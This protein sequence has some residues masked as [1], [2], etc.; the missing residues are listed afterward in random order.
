[1]IGVIFVIV[2]SFFALL[3][4]ELIAFALLYEYKTCFLSP[5][6]ILHLHLTKILHLLP[7]IV[8]PEFAM[9][10]SSLFLQGL[11]AGAMS[12]PISDDNT[13][14]LEKRIGHTGWMTSYAADDD[15]CERDPISGADS[16]KLQ[17]NHFTGASTPV[18]FT[19]ASGTDN[20]GIYFGSGTNKV[21]KV[22]F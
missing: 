21:S 1:M 6:R 17:W 22:G 11:C 12:Q 8:C 9:H 5:Q 13:P 14:S 16:S 2:P 4:D 15:S 19:L 7:S 20:V 18:N 3:I 10:L